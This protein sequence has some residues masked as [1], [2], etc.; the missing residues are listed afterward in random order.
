MSWLINFT[1]DVLCRYKVHE[2]GR[3]N[4]EMVTGH[5]FKQ[6]T[7]GFAE[8]VNYKITTGKGNRSKM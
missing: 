8:K 7:C 4:Y 5:R 2:N 3:T 1:G 6:A